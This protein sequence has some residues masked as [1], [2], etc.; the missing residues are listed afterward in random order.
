MMAFPKFFGR[1][2]VSILHSNFFFVLRGKGSKATGYY[3]LT[4][5]IFL[6]MPT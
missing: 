5:S 4:I 6:L 1:F 2:F 3:G